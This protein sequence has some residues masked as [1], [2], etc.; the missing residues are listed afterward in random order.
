M[1]LKHLYI[2][3]YLDDY[4]RNNTPSD[5]VGTSKD[6]N[7]AQDFADGDGYVY[8]VKPDKGVD[9]NKELGNR[10]PFPNE[11]EVVIPGGVKPENIKGATPV[12]KD[13]SLSNSTVLNPNHYKKPNE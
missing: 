9:V 7:V 11:Q 10:S 2:Y 6:P 12:N 1:I 4:A 3:H 13:G 8:T 5:Y